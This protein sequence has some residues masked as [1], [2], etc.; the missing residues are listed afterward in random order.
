MSK[1]PDYIDR[2][3]LKLR[4]EYGKDELVA[5]LGR[6]ID[7]KDIQI[8]QLLSEIQHLEH[9]VKRKEDFIQ[10]L[11]AMKEITK[12]A[13]KELK[14]EELYNHLKAAN[15][16]LRKKVRSLREKNKELIGKMA[17]IQGNH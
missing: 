11:R 3:I 8:G 7:E 9:E 4:R 10:R 16:T 1:K 17:R 14:K 12:E 2:T 15:Q 6:Q 13:K 5:A